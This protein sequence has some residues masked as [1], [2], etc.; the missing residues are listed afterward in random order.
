VTLKLK[1][2][3][4]SL[5]TRRVSLGDPTQLAD[6]IYRTARGLF[7]QLGDAGPFRLLGCGISD[8]STAEGADLSGDLLDPGA[9]Q[10][11]DAERATDSIRNRFG[12]KSIVKGRAL[13]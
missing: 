5:V 13:R 4:F 8:L 1:R 11:S 2:G 7:D 6:R 3:D 12:A 9:G 10:R